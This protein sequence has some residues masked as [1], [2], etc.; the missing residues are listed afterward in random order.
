MSKRLDLDDEA[1]AVVSVVLGVSALTWFDS[2]G[3]KV[4][5]WLRG[6][7]SLELVRLFDR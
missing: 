7:I 5:N 1:S 2:F 6:W 3:L 4:Q